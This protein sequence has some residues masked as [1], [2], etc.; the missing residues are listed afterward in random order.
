LVFSHDIRDCSVILLRY[1]KQDYVDMI[2]NLLKVLEKYYQR[3]G[4][5]FITITKN[6]IRI[7]KL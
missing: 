7:K 5:Y 2:K 6:Q 1:G 4:H 3:P